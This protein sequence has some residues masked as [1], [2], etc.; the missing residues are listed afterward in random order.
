MV[1]APTV[2]EFYASA[3]KFAQSALEAHHRGDHQRAAIDAGTRC[4]AASRK[5][6]RNS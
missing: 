6:A 1:T 4:S 5:G 2:D 3:A